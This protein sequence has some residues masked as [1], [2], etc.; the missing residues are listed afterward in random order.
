MVRW[1]PSLL[2][3]FLVFWIGYIFLWFPVIIDEVLARGL[4]ALVF[5]AALVI[6]SLVLY[7][8]LLQY[9]G[10]TIDH[11]VSRWRMPAD[12]AARRLARAMAAR[13]VR[14]P[15]ERAGDR[16]TFDLPPLTI[17]V[18]PGQFWTRVMVGPSLDE[19]ELRVE[20]LKAFVERTLAKTSS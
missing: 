11:E 16:V 9:H 6:G 5:F 14:P 12:E 3:F 17:V 7:A 1:I 8:A 18:A 4:L 13:G 19:N 10:G 20:R 2:P 15:V